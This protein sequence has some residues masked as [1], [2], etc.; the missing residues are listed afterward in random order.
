MWTGRLRG[1]GKTNIKNE[2]YCLMKTIIKKNNKKGQVSK[3]FKNNHK[4]LSKTSSETDRKSPSLVFF[5]ISVQFYL[6]P[7]TDRVTYS[8]LGCYLDCALN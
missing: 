4:I 7:L 2:N 6:K 1:L 3:F 8:D 5:Q